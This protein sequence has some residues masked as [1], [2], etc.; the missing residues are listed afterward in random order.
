MTAKLIQYSACVY[1]PLT[2]LSSV[3][4]YAVIKLTGKKR[5][6]IFASRMVIL[7][8]FSTAC[9]SFKAIKLKFCTNSS[10]YQYI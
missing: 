1:T 5:I 8:S 7:V 6:V 4:K 10:T 9:E 3:E 2:P